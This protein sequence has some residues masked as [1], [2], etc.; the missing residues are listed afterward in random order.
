M[1]L[2]IQR[3]ADL[4]TELTKLIEYYEDRLRLGMGKL[5]DIQ[6]NEFQERTEEFQGGYFKAV[7]DIY[8]EEITTLIKLREKVSEWVTR[9]LKTQ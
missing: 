4:I 6:I 5:Q 2:P 7:S 3:P 1:D 9:K 8:D